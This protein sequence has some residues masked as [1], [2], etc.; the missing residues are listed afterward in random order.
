MSKRKKRI[1]DRQL[2]LFDDRID[3]YIT[4]KQELLSKPA[5]PR[6]VQNWEEAAIEV[7]VSLKKSIAESGIPRKAI[8]DKVNRY[9]GWATVEEYKKLSKAT[10]KGI[11][12]LSLEMLNH[13]L[14]K[15]TEYPIPTYYIYAI[16]NVTGSLEACQAFAG[17]EGAR[18]ISGDEVRHMTLGKIDENILELRRLKKELRK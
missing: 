13:Y 12:H 16:Q 18:V 8:P 2:S 11:K 5:P 14:S 15:P 6:S 9:F 4:L 1:D 10:R 17:A 3:E 7:A